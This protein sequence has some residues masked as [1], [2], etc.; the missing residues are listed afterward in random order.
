MAE[1]AKQQRLIEKEEEQNEENS[2]TNLPAED[3]MSTKR[4]TVV[5]K[6]VSAAMESNIV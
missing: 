2:T 6:K 4:K 5:E 3:R 1:K